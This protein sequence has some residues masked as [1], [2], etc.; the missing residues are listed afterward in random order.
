MVGVKGLE[1]STS[2]SQTPRASQ[3]RHTPSSDNYFNLRI[4][5]TNSALIVVACLPLDVTNR[6]LR[7]WFVPSWK[8]QSQLQLLVSITSKLTAYVAFLLSI[9]KSAMGAW[10]HKSFKRTLGIN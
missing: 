2:A 9:Y 10:F 5:L 1:P 7:S 8:K 3:L 6:L 4:I